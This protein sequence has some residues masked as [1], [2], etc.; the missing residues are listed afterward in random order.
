[1]ASKLEKLQKIRAAV[2]KYEDTLVH[3][4]SLF[5]ADGTVD[6]NEQ[7]LLDKLRGTIQRTVAEIDVREKALSQSEQQENA[8]NAN[9]EQK[10]D[11]KNTDDDVVDHSLMKEG[12]ET[13]TSSGKSISASVGKKGKNVK[14]DVQTVQVILRDQHGASLKGSGVCG[15]KTIKAIKSFQEK[16]GV[17]ASGIIEPGDATWKALD[18]GLTGDTTSGET[19]DEAATVSSGKSISASV[20]KKGKNVKADVQ[21]VQVML[22]DKNDAPLSGSGISGP[23]TVKAIQAFQEKM[24]LSKS[25]L[26]EPG[27]ATWKALDTAKAGAMEIDNIGPDKGI[28]AQA[29]RYGYDTDEYANANDRAGIGNNANKL[30]AGLSVALSPELYEKLGIG[31]KSGAFIWVTFESG[32]T[33]KFQTGDET[34]R[35]LTNDRVDFYDPK[36]EFKSVDGQKLWV[37]VA[38]SSGSSE[39]APAADTKEGDSNDNITPITASVGKKGKNIKADVQTIQKLLNTKGADLKGSGV[40]GPKTIKYIKAFQATNMNGFNDGVVDPGGRT[41]QLLIGSGKNIDP[42]AASNDTSGGGA[43]V[44]PNWIK[45]AEGEIGTRENTSKTKHDPRVMEYHASVGG[46]HNDETPW[47]SSFVNWVMKKAGKGGTGSAV[48]V[49][50]KKYG[51]KLSRPA[52]GAIAVIDWDGPGPG[53]KG[54]VG[55]VVGKKG[56]SIQLLGGNQANAV[57]IKTFSTSKI[58]AYVVPSGYDV[59]ANAYTFGKSTGNYG[60]G[61]GMDATR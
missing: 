12:E 43:Y 61:G 46:I 39:A 9:E 3:Y 48:A 5:K 41:W 29:T 15:P 10:A 11:W 42:N 34:R 26:I 23:K 8:L 45:I 13:A 17:D 57:N 22:R 16:A 25:G 49:S 35:G 36:G 2:R 30:T 60:S 44:K 59:P 58:V 28:I 27:D 50:W 20:G 33:R 14:A 40:C 54:H 32:K 1:M 53:W 18:G 47:C 37:K 31:R 38:S 4:E 24:G 7:A 19:S 55:F 52:Y 6:A 56:N 51:K 21:T